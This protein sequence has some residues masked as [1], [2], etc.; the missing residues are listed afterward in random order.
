MDLSKQIL[1]AYAVYVADIFTSDHT[2][3]QS[4]ATSV[5]MQRMQAGT[6]QELCRPN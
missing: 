3:T 5:V 6:F 4:K 1:M 2:V